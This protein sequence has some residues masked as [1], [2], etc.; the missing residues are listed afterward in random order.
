M[1]ESNKQEN[2]SVED[3]ANMLCASI[4]A[5]ML[6]TLD[7]DT[8]TIEGGTALHIIDM[9]IICKALEEVG[10]RVL[11]MMSSQESLRDCMKKLIDTMHFEDE[12][13]GKDDAAE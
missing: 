8:I 2:M 13:R 5:Q 3:L 6:I 9:Y 11:P 4:S 12:Q 7:N 10:K 1:D